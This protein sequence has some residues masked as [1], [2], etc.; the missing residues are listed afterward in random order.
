MQ[1]QPELL[2]SSVW[3]LIRE[4]ASKLGIKIP[5]YGSNPII[6]GGGSEGEK[7]S[8]LSLGELA[9]DS[10]YSEWPEDHW[11]RFMPIPFDFTQQPLANER[12]KE[13]PRWADCKWVRLETNPAYDQPTDYYQYRLVA[14]ARSCVKPN[15]RR[16]SNVM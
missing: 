11:S 7:S 10:S 5:A 13:E 14:A 8:C 2:C 9:L 16:M 3:A 15:N 6:S 4:M 12:F 1:V